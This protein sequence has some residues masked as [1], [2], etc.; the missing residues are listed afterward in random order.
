MVGM[1]MWEKIE[2]LN[3]EKGL[4]WADLAR[5]IGVKDSRISKWRSGTGEVDRK[6][7]LRIAKVLGSGVEYLADDS[8]EDPRSAQPLTKDEEHVVQVYRNLRS[9]GAIDEALATHGMAMAA[10]GL[11]AN[12]S[13]PRNE[14]RITAETPDDRVP[15]PE[16]YDPTY[17]APLRPKEPLDGIRSRQPE[18]GAGEAGGQAPKEATPAPRRRKPG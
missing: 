12:P 18:P 17:R 1:D 16:G 8:I 10:K 5:L 7:L 11:A 15:V 14:I 6:Q 9:L 4:N 3:G 13:R 2:R